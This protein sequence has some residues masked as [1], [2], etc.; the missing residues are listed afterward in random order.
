[1]SRAGS[2]SKITN[3]TSTKKFKATLVN[4]QQII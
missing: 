1:M 2:L 3:S 4:N